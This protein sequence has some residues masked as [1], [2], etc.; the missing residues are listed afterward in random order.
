[1]RTTNK[2]LPLVTVVVVMLA[3]GTTFAQQ[4]GRGGFGGLPAVEIAATEA[5][6]K[7]LGLSGDVAGKLKLLRD[8]YRAAAQ[9]EYQTA[10]IDFQNLSAESRQKL[11]DISNKLNAEFDP[12]VKALIGAD[13]TKR[14]EQVQ[15]QYNV[16]NSA[17]SALT[18]ADVAAELKL[19]DEQKQKLNDLNAEFGRRQRELFGGGGGGQE[20]FAKLREERTAKAMDVLTAEQKDKLKALQGSPF[21]VTQISSGLGRRGKGN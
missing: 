6:Q 15:L 13:A 10:G 3:A 12:K 8:D 17:P 11:A 2:F 4:R 1:M 21:D 9:K 14:F 16:R 18:A 20:A 7:E 5:V 19:S